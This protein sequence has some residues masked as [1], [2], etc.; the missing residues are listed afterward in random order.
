LVCLV[1]ACAK[2]PAINPEPPLGEHTEEVTPPPGISGTVVAVNIFDE[3]KSVSAPGR[4]LHMPETT[5][6]GQEDEVYPPL[7]EDI[8]GVIREEVM[9]DVTEGPK[10]IEID[11]YVTAG[12]Q[13]FLVGEMREVAEVRFAVRIEVIGADNAR[14]VR[15]AEGR[16]EL[17][18]DGIDVPRVDVDALYIEAVRESLRRGFVKFAG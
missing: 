15:V 10:R 14:D 11:V 17:S 7:G 6:V 1:A 8:R 9:N 12:R 2:P 13:S 16:A 4:V 3:R 5:I 18:T